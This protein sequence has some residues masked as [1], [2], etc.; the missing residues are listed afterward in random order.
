LKPKTIYKIS[1]YQIH[2]NLATKDDIRNIPPCEIPNDLG[3]LA[4]KQDINNIQVPKE[5]IP[6]DLARKA[7][8]EDLAKESTT[9]DI[10][11]H[12]WTQ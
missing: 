1:I 10:K 6:E 2:W 4:I 7:D 9:I 8:L 3:H 11:R 5:E 12:N